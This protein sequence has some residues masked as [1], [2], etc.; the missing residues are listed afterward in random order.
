MIDPDENALIYVDSIGIYAQTMGSQSTAPACRLG[1]R[2]FRDELARHAQISRH[3]ETIERELRRLVTRGG[4]RAG[5][6]A[7]R[8]LR[9]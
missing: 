9:R 7:T 1:E 4:S 8:Y 2:G 3:V 6:G 5:L